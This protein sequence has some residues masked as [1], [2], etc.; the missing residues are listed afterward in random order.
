[1]TRDASRFPRISVMAALLVAVLA[2]R[3]PAELLKVEIRER[4]PYAQGKPFGE[5]GAYERLRGKLF[6]AVDPRAPVNQRIIDID[7]AP[8]GTDGRVEFSAD[9]EILAPADLKQANGAV[10]YDVNNRGGP[11][12]LGM[13]NGDGD[14]FLFRQGYIV[15]WSGWIAEVLPGDR[16]LRLDAPVAM[17]NGRPLRGLIR[18]EM[19]PD[20]A[21]ER[22]TIA[23][24]GNQGSYP[25]SEDGLN[26]ARLTWRLREQD[27]RVLIPREQWRLE[28]RTIEADGETGQLPLIEMVLAGGFQPGYLYELVY[29]GEGSL[30]QGT[31]LAGIRDFISFLKNCADD[32][33]TL[34]LA[35][36]S[37]A[38][39]FAY[40]F[41][42]SQSGR[43]LRMFLY[44]GF[45]TD[46][47]GRRVFDGLM[48]HVAGAGL[49]FFN[50]RFASP[51]RHNGQ[52]DNH[53]FPADFFP[54][55]Y[56]GEQDPCSDHRSVDGILARAEK[57]GTMPLVMH[58]QSTS[59]YWHRA[60]SLVHTDPLG[61]RDGVIPNN[62]RIYTFGG[63]QHGPGDGVARPAGNGQ[64]P[65]NPA[66][67]RPFLRGLLT[68]MDRWVR[69]GATPPAS[70]FP[71]I[72]EGSLVGF[73][74]RESGWKEIP[75]VRYPGVI[76][77]PGSAYRGPL[78]ATRRISTVEPPEIQGLYG[79]KVPAYG[80]DNLE[81]GALNLPTVAVPIGS[82][83]GWN[84]RQRNIGAEQEL[85]GLAGGF[86]PLPKTAQARM[87]TGDPRRAI[88]E[89]YTDFEDYK[90]Q[91]MQAAESLV[92]QGYF[93]EE[94]LPRQSALCEKFRVYFEP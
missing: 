13:F 1:M 8:T 23:H 93:L 29:E 76:H 89:R 85:L 30:V 25:P 57:D 94:E 5:R 70:V 67:Y 51:T 65:H 7:L 15:A 64:L 3:S 14:D 71:K 81:M 43:C 9:F 38:I 72:S 66:D 86:I 28:Q 68:A 73:R 55:A 24:W 88:L 62:V 63:T 39:K 52:H 35:D 21:V 90:Q 80:E 75:G 46:E 53:L 36:G 11:T 82:Y 84:L 47:S 60:G 10:L 54:F 19:A 12:C 41:G 61:Q 79:V 87:Q 16:R 74:Q 26:N 20:Q 6:F 40:G 77:Q 42:T 37:P 83:V 56:G 59:E 33:Q 44:D 58:T 32:R 2:C 69:E 18:A 27:E 92:R 34:R 91:F 22:M 31:G 50:H 45:N 49:G 78:F 48:P 17:E 4:E